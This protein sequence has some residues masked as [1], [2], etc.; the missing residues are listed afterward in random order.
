MS[1]KLRLLLLIGFHWLAVLGA[2]AGACGIIIVA[3]SGDM[4]ELHSPLGI[5]LLVWSADAF[6]LSNQSL[7]C[8]SVLIVGSRNAWFCICTAVASVNQGL[9]EQGIAN[10]KISLSEADAVALSL[11]HRYVAPN[12]LDRHFLRHAHERR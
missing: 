2:F 5:I 10:E 7:F 1:E 3:S 12:G 9:A 6:D 8:P 11:E 4:P